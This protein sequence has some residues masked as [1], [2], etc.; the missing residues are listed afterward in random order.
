M[1]YYAWDSFKE[2]EDYGKR[3]VSIYIIYVMCVCLGCCC[4]RM[5]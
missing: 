4:K 5:L 3:T 2:I 1:F